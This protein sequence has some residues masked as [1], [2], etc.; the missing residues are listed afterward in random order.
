MSWSKEDRK[1]FESSE[2]FKNMEDKIIENYNKLKGIQSHANMKDLNDA[3]SDGAPTADNYAKALKSV[4]NVMDSIN[5]S[6]D[7]ELE[8][9]AVDEAG[10]HQVSGE[11]YSVSVTSNKIEDGE[12]EEEYFKNTIAELKKIAY[13]AAIAGDIRLAYKVE[14]AIGEII[15]VRD[16]DK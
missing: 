8:S 6:D 11:G 5:S 14:R 9:N 16:E 12:L 2:V 4:E 13:D 3:M 1:I 10:N 15:E 7:S